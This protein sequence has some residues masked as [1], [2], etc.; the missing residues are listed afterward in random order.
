M[1]TVGLT[2]AQVE[3]LWRF[4]RHTG[5]KD[6]IGGKDGS[7]QVGQVGQVTD[8]VAT[9]TTGVRRSMKTYEDVRRS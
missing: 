6:K 4:G 2:S 9:L 3:L 7:W 5:G 1:A 8:P